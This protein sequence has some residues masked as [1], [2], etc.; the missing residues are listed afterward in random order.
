MIYVKLLRFKRRFKL[1]F[2]DRDFLERIHLASLKILEEIGVY[3]YSLRALRILEDYGCDVDR[4]SMKARINQDLVGEALRKCPREFTLYGRNP[5]YNIYL[6]GSQTYLFTNGT[7]T[8]IMDLNTG[9]RRRAIYRDLV[10]TAVLADALE[11]MHGY[12]PTV[13]PS[14]CPEYLHGLYELE[15]S[16][17]N[18]EKH[19]MLGSTSTLKEA[20][21]Q[22]KMAEAIT[23]DGELRRKPIISSV[24]CTST[25][26]RLDGEATDAALKFAES[27]VPI[28]VMSMPIQGV[29]SPVTIA[30]SISMANAEILSVVSIIQLAYP[31][32][33]LMYALDP[34]GIEPKVGR[35]TACTPSTLLINCVSIQLAREYYNMPCGNGFT[36]V[37]KTPDS[38]AAYEAALT[39]LSM[40]ASGADIVSG[41][42]GLENYNVFS[43]EQFLIDYEVCTLIFNMLNGFN[44]DEENLALNVIS[45]RMD[46]GF[47]LSDKHTLKHIRSLW[48]P[49]ISDL[50]PYETWIRDG[51]KN[52]TQRARDKAREI[53]ETHKPKPLDPDIRRKLKDI[54]GEM[55]KNG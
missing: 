8:L 36:S 55:V 25:P 51:G 4:V 7:C 32:T 17:N 16:L 31:G 42:G 10:E 5:D 29:S 52:T 30:G 13:I 20:E 48:I 14:D 9:V 54:I 15:A 1:N 28:R 12:Y 3:V 23:G 41:P 37:S 45:R 21:L 47:F 39:A 34:I 6:D 19:I 27:G 18:T 26:L 50:N 35:F 22:V 49:L 44:I 33:P 11:G 40:M 2:V 43:Y 24:F 38:Q 46:S 53:L